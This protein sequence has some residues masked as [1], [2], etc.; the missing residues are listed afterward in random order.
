MKIEQQHELVEN[1]TH[2]STSVHSVVVSVF[3]ITADSTP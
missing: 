1:P 2:F 3:G